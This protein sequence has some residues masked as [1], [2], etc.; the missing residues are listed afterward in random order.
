MLWTEVPP[1][2]SYKDGDEISCSII[3]YFVKNDLH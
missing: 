1:M 3:T 2:I